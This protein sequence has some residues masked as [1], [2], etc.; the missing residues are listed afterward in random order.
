MDGRRTTFVQNMPA[1]ESAK[2][3]KDNEMPNTPTAIPAVE[4]HAG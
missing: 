3:A 2:A 4:T 1:A